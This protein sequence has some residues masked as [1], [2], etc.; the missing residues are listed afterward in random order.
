MANKAVVIGKANNNK[1]HQ[2]DLGLAKLSV[3]PITGFAFGT[4]TLE[5][6]GL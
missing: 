6:L 4:H 5:S 3:M 2:S 1:D